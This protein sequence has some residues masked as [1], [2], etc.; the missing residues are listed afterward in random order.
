MLTLFIAPNCPNTT[1]KCCSVSSKLIEPTYIRDKT[2]KER[3]SI[4]EA[5]AGLVDRKR[6]G[7]GGGELFFPAV[8]SNYKK[9]GK[10]NRPIF[11]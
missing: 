5:K 4:P 6:G 8:F 1:R 11:F 10:K 3:G 2:D 9:K 7:I